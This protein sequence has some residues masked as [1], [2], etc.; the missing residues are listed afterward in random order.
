MGPKDLYSNPGFCTQLL[1]DLISVFSEKLS[2]RVELLVRLYQRHLSFPDN[3]N[4]I[5]FPI[6]YSV[7]LTRM[8]AST[9]QGLACPDH[10]SIP[11]T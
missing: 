9:G 4:S 10:S 8:E 7:S 1:H 6:P 3:A 2:L 11:S 5:L